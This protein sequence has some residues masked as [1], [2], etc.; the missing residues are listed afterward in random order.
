[1]SDFGHIRPADLV[2]TYEELTLKELLESHKTL[3]YLDRLM[4]RSDKTKSREEL[5]TTLN[6]MADELMTYEITTGKD[7]N[8]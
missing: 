7:L 2:V 6:K 8:A 4:K 5:L 1:M 3:R